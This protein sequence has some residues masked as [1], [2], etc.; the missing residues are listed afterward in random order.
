GV[1]STR[2]VEL[3]RSLGADHV[4]DYT[5]EDFTRNG[6]RYDLVLDN[7]GS[8]TWAEY[9]RVLTPNAMFII[10][11]APKTKGPIG[12]LGQI[13]KIRLGSLRATQHVTFFI[14]QFNRGDMGV[15]RELIEAGKVTPFVERTYSLRETTQAMHYQ[16]TGHA[17]GKIVIS[18]KE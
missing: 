14:A 9:K 17:R 8:R 6:Q 18:I 16:G 3:V 7:A 4:I 13:L 12:P 1:C 11:G 10:V 2:N 5:R 15:L